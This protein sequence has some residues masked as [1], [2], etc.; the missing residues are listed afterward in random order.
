MY[1]GYLL[2]GL[3]KS[4]ETVKIIYEQSQ[5]N[6]NSVKNILLSEYSRQ[7]RKAILAKNSNSN[8]NNNPA[9]A[10]AFTAGKD[11]RGDSQER[12]LNKGRGGANKSF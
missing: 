8:S 1:T 11:G 7:K 3:P 10:H 6:V 2:H 4:Y 12:G 9:N 5:N